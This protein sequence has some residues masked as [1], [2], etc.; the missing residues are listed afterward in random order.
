MCLGG[1]SGPGLDRVQT[2]NCPLCNLPRVCVWVTPLWCT[3]YYGLR[4]KIFLS[5]GL[6]FGF[7]VDWPAGCPRLCL[8][9]CFSRLFLQTF[10]DVLCKFIVT[11]ERCVV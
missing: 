3:L 1:A 5:Y 9:L 10:N 2:E 6:G 7:W 8:I 11:F 4:Y